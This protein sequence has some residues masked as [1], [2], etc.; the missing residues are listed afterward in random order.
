[1][2]ALPPLRDAVLLRRYKRFLADVRFRDGSTATVHCPNPGAMTGLA[3]PGTAILVSESGNPRRKL[4]FTWELARA[5]RTWVCVNTAV[6]N[7]V[8]GRWL[9]AG[10]PLAGYREVRREVA[11]AGSR[12]DFELD[13]RC[14]VEVKTVTL[15]TGR[16]GAF[17]DAVTERG[18]RHLDTLASM[19]GTRRVL[20]YFVAR[21]DVRAVRPADEI[22]PAYG[23]ALRRAI[24]AGVE[25]LAAQARFSRDGVRRGPLLDVIV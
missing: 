4:R 7:R 18:R 12:F 1:L 10:H 20:L 19:R 24:D 23:A 21:G 15:K 6:A 22:D 11:R 5:G 16:V 9:E 8:V 13:G 25:V 2:R 17:P 3:E 14:V